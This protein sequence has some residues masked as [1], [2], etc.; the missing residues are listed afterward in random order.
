MACALKGF[1]HL[2]LA[3]RSDKGRVLVHDWAESRAPKYKDVNIAAV[4]ACWWG[5]TTGM[6]GHPITGNIEDDGI[7][8]KAM[9]SNPISYDT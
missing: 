6:L 4:E 1:L 7:E 2:H 8:L 3:A 9:V 5:T